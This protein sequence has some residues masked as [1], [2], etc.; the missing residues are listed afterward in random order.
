MTSEFKEPPADD[1]LTAEVDDQRRHKRC[2]IKEPARLLFRGEH[3]ACM[4][5]DLSGDGALV[6]SRIVPRVGE[7]VMLEIDPLGALRG[8]IVRRTETGLAL[9]FDIDRASSE[10]IIE[11]LTLLINRQSSA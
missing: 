10:A 2:A 8:T 6:K 1:E 11:R 5:T 7:A 4:I 3:Y 9:R